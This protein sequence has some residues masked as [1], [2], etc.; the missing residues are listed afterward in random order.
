LKVT[1]AFPEQSPVI[2][3]VP[4]AGVWNEPVSVSDEA[5]APTMP[6]AMAPEATRRA[7]FF[8]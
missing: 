7:I 1:A 2:L 4:W 8:M 3:A 5:A 6:K